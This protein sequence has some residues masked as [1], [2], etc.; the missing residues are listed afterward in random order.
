MTHASAERAAP[1]AMTEIATQGV[2]PTPRPEAR[3]ERVPSSD[4]ISGIDGIASPGMLRDAALTLDQAHRNLGRIDTER[5]VLVWEGLLRG[6]VS[7]VDWF[8]S[9][10]RRFVLV[11]LNP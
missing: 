9:N 1:M 5:A 2:E 6:R 8:D 3:M 11:R 7:L 10:G 4:A